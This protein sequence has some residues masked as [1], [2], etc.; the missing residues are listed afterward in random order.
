MSE[1]SKEC[2]L[3]QKKP[4]TTSLW[5][6]TKPNTGSSQRLSSSCLNYALPGL[7]NKIAA[8]LQRLLITRVCHS[9]VNGHDQLCFPC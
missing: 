6:P 2:R 9:F 5:Q 1:G 8:Q 4:A 3:S 7:G